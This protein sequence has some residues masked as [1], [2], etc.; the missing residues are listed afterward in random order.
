M[1]SWFATG[2]FLRFFYV[3]ISTIAA[4][5]RKTFSRR[6]TPSWWR[7]IMSNRAIG[8]LLAT[9]ACAVAT[10]FAALVSEHLDH[11]NIIML[12]LVAVVAVGLYLGRGPSVWA[13]FLSVACFDFFFVPPLYLFAVDDPQYLL[14]FTVMLGVALVI[15]QLT[16][17]L[18]QQADLARE[19]ELR[20]RA[21][22]EMARELAGAN[23]LQSIIRAA[24]R[25][26]HDAI[27][28]QGAVL[29]PDDRGQLAPVASITPERVRVEP[30]MASMAYK[31]TQCMD[32]TSMYPSG[33]FPLKAPARVG[34]VLIV[35]S[36]TATTAYL[37]EHKGLLESA[38]SLMA[39]TIERLRAG[40]SLRVAHA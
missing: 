29:L 30:L 39:V 4:G 32:T 28:A 1:P 35:V 24:D 9:L 26:L 27:G 21:L 11:A 18:R 13:A 38:A 37:T 34:G 2:N 7:R 10:A 12:Y 23:D 22:Y 19:R 31:G 36:P 25:F 5:R 33:Y 8:Y 17:G 14:T 16:A 20:A 6:A 40:E 3:G 15:G